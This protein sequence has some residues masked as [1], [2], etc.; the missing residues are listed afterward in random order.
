MTGPQGSHVCSPL[1][2]FNVNTSLK[3]KKVFKSVQ[4]QCLAILALQCPF[5]LYLQRSFSSGVCLCVRGGED[6]GRES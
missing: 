6:A 3:K 4:S 1:P 5:C 2:G